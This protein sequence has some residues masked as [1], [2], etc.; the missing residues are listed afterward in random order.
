MGDIYR[1]R[2]KQS[3]ATV[4]VKM[5][6]QRP[7]AV[8]RARFRREAEVLAALRHPG[9]VG[10]VD[11]GTWPDG[12]AFLAMEWLEGEDLQARARREP[13]GMKASVEIVRR[14][15]AAL[16]AV[17]SRGV[18]HRD[19]KLSNLWLVAGKALSVKV[20]DFGVVKP[21]DPDGFETERG[22]IIGTPHY[23]APEQVRG[24]GVTPRADVY[25]LGAVLF[26]LVTGRVIFPTEHVVALLGQLV[27]DDPPRA[28]SVRLDVP[29]A[30]DAVIS[31]AT[32]RRPDDRFADAGE[33]ARALAR[34]GVVPTEAPGKEGSSS[35]VRRVPQ[36][37]AGDDPARTTPG[38]IMARDQEVRVVTAVVA[39]AS[40]PEALAEAERAAQPHLG[41]ED[42]VEVLPGHQ[43]VLVFGAHGSASGG[44]PVR[45]ARAALALVA[46]GATARAAI[47]VGRAVGGASREALELAAAELDQ[48]PPGGVRVAPSA[49]ALLS[50]HFVMRERE[51]GVA[52]LYEGE[53]ADSVRRLL[54]KATPTVGRDKELGLLIGVYR[55]MV[56]DGAP[57]VAV[58]SGPP[59]I[60]KSRVRWEVT[61]RLALEERRPELWVC[62]GDPDVRGAGTPALGRAIAERVGLSK[63]QA[64][65]AQRARVAAFAPS[66]YEPECRAL[67]ELSRPV[68][69]APRLGADGRRAA[70][71]LLRDRAARAPL[72][73]VLEDLHWMD[74]MTIE[75][76]DAALAERRLPLLVLGF[77][78]ADQ[79]PTR[80]VFSERGATRLELGPLSAG[81][82]GRLVSLVAPQLGEASREALI[83]RAGGNAL[84]LEELLRAS[85]ERADALPITV[86][87]LV[88]ARLD[89]LAP[90][91]RKVARALSVFGRAAWTAGV[92]ALLD[93]DPSD[94]LATLTAFE[95]VS[96]S[97]AHRFS[98]EEE[99]AFSH[100]LVR[101]AIYASIDH[102]T[103]VAWHLRAARWLEAIGEED[104]G[105]VARHAAGG[106]DPRAA[107]ALF[108]RAAEGAWSSG[109]TSDAVTLASEGLAAG[110][111][112]AVEARL[113]LVGATAALV[114][115][116]LGGAV[117]LARV[118]I[119]AAPAQASPAR[120]V[121][122]E[123][124]FA[125]GH[126]EEALALLD[127]DD[128][129]RPL[130][131]CL[132]AEAERLDDARGCLAAAPDGPSRRV[133]HVSVALLGGE[134]AEAGAL[135]AALER[136]GERPP[137]ELAWRVRI[138]TL[139]HAHASMELE[140]VRD[141]AGALITAARARGAT[142]VA[143]LAELSQQEAEVLDGRRGERLAALSA[144]LEVAGHAAR[145]RALAVTALSLG[146]SGDVAAALPLAREAVDR[147]RLPGDARVARRALAFV[148]ASRG[149]HDAALELSLDDTQRTRD[150]WQHVADWVRVR[151][152]L[153]AGEPE[154]AERARARAA[155]R[156][157]LSATWF[158]RALLGMD[159]GGP[160]S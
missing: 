142:L 102:E 12:R 125:E 39:S 140:R 138:M 146:R 100:A 76:V 115:G 94:E 73:L 2:D 74:D 52:L 40:D 59:G 126:V 15:A 130:R 51:G 22:A 152:L 63:G 62:R 103:R 1:A 29:E 109:Q 88:Q 148:H 101:D 6:R 107:A 17:H 91:A 81:A 19:L 61:R 33:L 141:L 92:Q 122:A 64:E 110:A 77:G 44:D 83:E 31:R 129:R 75:I 143:S 96:P 117:R 20:I 65:E 27:S 86:S 18:V 53:R 54:G 36:A 24:E 47:A 147:A 93:E 55:E 95:I 67:V 113:A 134:T 37:A 72:V 87:A 4:A 131:A 68:S 158:G 60:G 108:A 46:Q 155:S 105:V 85:P 151:A 10:Y 56:E 48:T 5:L 28:S 79:G 43:L 49:V 137:P 149:A 133:A 38:A 150:G 118:A 145:A 57:R 144:A 98:G 99:W 112:G 13:L 58:V 41:P 71:S 121:L 127:G 70:L 50:D 104:L 3:G 159:L 45:A 11:H 128:A 69:D 78:R 90:Q 123:A 34:V 135:L 116:E 23:L 14:A 154:E 89:Q 80:A 120:A 84:F 9:V 66:L 157:H 26:R 106:G 111:S 132:L 160:S 119:A 124:R 139:A 35:T 7:D 97:D 42:A 82:A 114:S 30:L 16:A 8:A 153:A 136:E 21:A 156:P 32:S 25:S